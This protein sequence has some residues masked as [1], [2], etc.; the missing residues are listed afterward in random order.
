[1]PNY[2]KKYLT[3]CL[4]LFLFLL[5][6]G[7]F[8]SY[9]NKFE[10]NLTAA[11]F[12]PNTLL[13]EAPS[14]RPASGFAWNDNVGW[15]N[16][17]TTTSSDAGR[18]YVSDNR[19]YGYAWGENIGWIS[20]NC[21]NTDSDNNCSTYGVTQSSSN[22]TLTGYAWGEN[23]GWI[24]FA[25]TGTD[26][27]VKV[28]NNTSGTNTFSGYAWG[29]N[30]GWISFNNSGDQAVTTL[31]TR[32]HSGG[33]GTPTCTY[34]DPIWGPCKAP[35]IQEATVEANNQNCTGEITKTVQQEC[36]P[37]VATSTIKISITQATGTETVYTGEI[38]Q[39]IATVTGTTTNNGVTW[40]VLPIDNTDFYGTISDTGVYIAPKQAVNVTIVAR[41]MADINVMATTSLIVRLPPPNSPI[42]IS[43]TPVDS[44]ILIN[45][46][47]S[48]IASV[49]GTTTNNDVTWLVYPIETIIDNFYGTIS[50]TG[51]YTAPGHAVNVIIKATAHANITKVAKTKVFVRLPDVNTA[52][53]TT[54]EVVTPTTNNMTTDGVVTNPPHPS[55]RGSSRDGGSSNNGVPAILNISSFVT[56]NIAVLGT[57]TEMIVLA[58][59]KILESPAGAAVANTITTVGVVGGG[60]AATSVFALN[61]TVVADLLFLPFRLWGLLLSALGLKKRNRPWGT[62]YDSVTKQPIDPA[63]V[64]LT[65]INSKEENTSITDLDGRYGFLVGSGKY[66]LSANKTNYTFP[67][68]KLAGKSEDVLYTNLY[69]GGE[70]NIDIA[71]ALINK[72][73]PMD[74]VKFDWNEFTKGKK[75]IMKFY[76]RREKILRIVTDWIFRIG[77]LV[78]LIS[79]FLVSAPYNLI[80]FGL[81]LVLWSLRMI[82]LTQKALG[83]LAEKDGSPLSFAII[84]I[85]D[86]ELKVEITNKVAN[87]IGRYYCLVNKGT[88]YVKVEKKNNDESYSEIFTSPVFEA[89]NGI[90]NQNF[91]I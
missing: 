59:Q 9:L 47:I 74:P 3:G 1:M 66:T 36:T 37:P 45:Q 72:N 73:I 12:N 82:G 71:G 7:S 2:F 32:P 62:V 29:E 49:T 50:D 35:G 42:G 10:L 16:F 89:K 85:F 24:N 41:S 53:S 65:N 69:L 27:D 21:A 79:L 61:G 70:I 39:F 84:R 40:T 8:N 52:T 68:T 14:A 26:T 60:V 64:T 30:I 56:K 38:I 54:D 23:I 76:S 28:T 55:S 31:W 88:Y 83:S 43:I 48:F 46:Q 13:T 81:Y 5:I 90:I 67:S 34:N 78:S 25:P 19:L 33:G 91:T 15:I 6:T 63:Y 44:T 22:G 11:V 18:V 20:M 86:A 57:T 80:I 17:G 77:F 4:F 87:K 58:T 75:E 51:L